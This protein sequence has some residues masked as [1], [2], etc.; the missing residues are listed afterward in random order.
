MPALD[1]LPDN[2]YHSYSGDNI[3]NEPAEEVVEWLKESA[4][5]ERSRWRYQDASS[6]VGTRPSSVTTRYLLARSAA[7]R[8][9]ASAGR[10]LAYMTTALNTWGCR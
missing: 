3:H 8:F 1:N 5:T 10:T 9:A 4:R 7:P 2:C 6:V